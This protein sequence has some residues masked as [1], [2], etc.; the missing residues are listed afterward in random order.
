MDKRKTIMDAL[1]WF[2][3][4]IPHYY[5]KEGNVLIECISEDIEASGDVGEIYSG[6]VEFNPYYY[7][8]ICTEEEYETLVNELSRPDEEEANV[9]TQEMV[10]NGELPEVGMRFMYLVKTDNDKDGYWDE[11]FAIAYSDDDLMWINTHGIQEVELHKIKP[12]DPRTPLEV[13]QEDQI[14][15][16][17]NLIVDNNESVDFESLKWMQENNMLAEI[18]L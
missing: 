5:N 18:K 13:A 14:N 16:F 3:G 1:N 8:Q 15:E 6:G 12:I 10:D 9:Y 17:Y 7:S 2:K 11:T 4:E